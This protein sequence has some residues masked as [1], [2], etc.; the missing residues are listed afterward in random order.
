MRRPEQ[1]GVNAFLKDLKVSEPSIQSL[2]TRCAFFFC[3]TLLPG[4]LGYL[5]EKL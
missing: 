3:T 5:R 2:S 4:H 1:Y